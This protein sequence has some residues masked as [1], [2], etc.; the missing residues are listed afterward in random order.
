MAAA[1]EWARPGGLAPAGPRPL[2]EASTAQAHV[3][4]MVARVRQSW[5]DPKHWGRVMRERF[6]RSIQT[7]EQAVVK[8]VVPG[9][10][11]LE[12]EAE[13]FVESEYARL[14]RMPAT[15]AWEM[16]DAAEWAQEAGIDLYQELTDT[17]QGLL[18]LFAAALFHIVEQQLLLFHRKQVLSLHEEDDIK[19][20]ERR[21]V[22]ERL[23]EAGVDL[24]DIMQRTGLDELELVANVAK[25]GDGRAAEKLR[26]RKAR[27][28]V[29]ELFRNEEGRLGEPRASVFTPLGGDG[30][31][32]SL[33]DFQR[34][35]SVAVTFW[36]EMANAVEATG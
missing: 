22:E 30:L 21:K 2:I 14:G 17:R 18:N 23:R 26:E 8:R 13:A 19:L 6:V 36:H 4:Q 34:Y 20:F 9:F 33:E 35:A 31:Y 24:T 3:S 11:N 10:E 1:S 29:H 25:H 16:G 12:Q 27:V 7:F 5:L 28:L 32:V 15:D